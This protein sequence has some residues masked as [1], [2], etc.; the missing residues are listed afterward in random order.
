M[1]LS[2]R[3]GITAYASVNFAR[4]VVSAVCGGSPP[5]GT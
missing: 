2:V 4:S 3:A 5:L 1:S